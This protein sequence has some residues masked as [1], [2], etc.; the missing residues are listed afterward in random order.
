MNTIIQQK[1][2]NNN[3]NIINEHLIIKN[4][5][6]V[7]GSFFLGAPGRAQYKLPRFPIKPTVR[8]IF[9]IPFLSPPDLGFL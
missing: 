1:I 2:K 6:L 7:N 3:K 8:R 4:E 5:H 9:Q